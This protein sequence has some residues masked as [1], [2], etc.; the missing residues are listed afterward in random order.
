MTDPHISF[1]TLIEAQRRL[2]SFDRYASPSEWIQAVGD[3]IAP[4]MGTDRI[5]FVGP[6]HSENDARGATGIEVL[7]PTLDEDFEDGIETDFVGYA[8]TGHSVF[9]EDYSTLL[10]Q[11][12]H[13]AGPAVVHDGPLYDERS[14]KELRLQAEVFDRVDIVRQ[15]A[16]SVPQRRGEALL[17]FGYEESGIPDPNSGALGALELLL[18]AYREAMRLRRSQADLPSLL[19]D[20]D[21]MPIPMMVVAELASW[22]NRAFS[23]L[24]LS[25]KELSDLRIECR[26]RGRALIRAIAKTSLGAS[27]SPH[28]TT[29]GSAYRAGSLELRVSVRLVE[30]FR[31]LVA[32]VQVEATLAIPPFATLRQAFGLTPKEHA[33]ADLLVRRYSDK[34]IASRLGLSYHTA[35][36]HVA[37]T[38]YQP[39]TPR[40]QLEVTLWRAL[41]EE[42]KKR[43]PQFEGWL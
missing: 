33:V 17:I 25:S 41:V 1:S 7:A 42:R 29:Y 32:L 27:T 34:E 31:E 14:R 12:V 6:V 8:P 36:Q 35:R 2:L 40:D 16:L 28:G 38:L 24:P 18:P 15:L 3:S 23:T 37:T 5:Y 11:L 4:V 20:F 26:R 22:D 43:L 39:K 30:R 13:A 21:G 19:A 10:H 9:S